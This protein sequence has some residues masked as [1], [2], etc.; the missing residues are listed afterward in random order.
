LAQVI[1]VN[2]QPTAVLTM[3][4]VEKRI[5]DIV[6]DF[7]R[8]LPT[9]NAFD[10]VVVGPLAQLYSADFADRIV[11]VVDALDEALT[12]PGSENIQSIVGRLD[13]LP[14]QV[15]C[16]LT[17]R[18]HHRLFPLLDKSTRYD[19]T[20]DDPSTVD[21]INAYVASRLSDL[22]EPTR[23]TLRDRIVRTSQGN[24]LYA[25][26][27][28]ADLLGRVEQGESPEDLAEAALPA[29]LSDLY[30]RSV[31]QVLRHKEFRWSG[32]VRPLL[33]ALVAASGDGLTA[34]Q[35]AELIGLDGDVVSGILEAFG[36]QLYGQMPD[37]PFC[38]FHASFRD[39]LLSDPEYEIDAGEAH[40]AMATFF[41]ERYRGN[42]SRCDDAYAIRYTATHILELLRASA[43]PQ[44]RERWLDE[45]LSL[46]ADRHYRQA[47]IKE[48]DTTSLLTDLRAAVDM[49]PAEDERR[50]WLAGLLQEVSQT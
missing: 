18:A 37:G 44:D 41:L 45:L 23:T 29:G 34:T 21:E 39:F 16:V 1:E 43:V 19:L 9:Q 13:L 33:A 49:L 14:P 8:A 12:W 22:P 5:H 35:L 20:A 31:D 38:I 3:D 28:V 10:Q 24:W 46:L 47:R 2:P 4:A 17:S 36:N 7:L 27:V 50:V 42:W 32:Q 26:L 11:I 48:S 25:R 30:R 15:R 40:R 6:L